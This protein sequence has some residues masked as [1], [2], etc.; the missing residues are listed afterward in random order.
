M[1]LLQVIPSTNP[2]GGGPME[3]VRQISGVLSALGHSTEIASTDA[4]GAPWLSSLP[5]AVHALGPG[6]TSY[7]YT[8]SLVPWLRENAPRF[9]A[10]IVNGLWQ[11]P[12]FAVRLALR[13][14]PTP[15]FVYTHGMLDPWFKRTYPL[16]HLKKSLYWRW[17]EYRVLRDA[18]AV[19]FT[20]E[21]EKLLA[22][23]SFALYR[24]NEVV[25]SLGTAGP[26]GDAAAQEAAFLSRHPELR[27]KRLLLF[28]GRIHAKKGCDLLV[29]AFTKVAA[30]APDLRLVM[31]G[32]DPSGLGVELAR[33]ADEAGAAG[34][35]VWPGMLTGDVKWG[36]FRAAEAF[37]LPSHQENFGIAVAE[38]L[39]CGLPALISDKVNIW[40]EVTGDGAGLVGEDTGE[41]TTRLLRDW[42]ALAPEAQAEMRRSALRCFSERFEIRHSAENLVRQLM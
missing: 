28:L 37:V 15:Y 16:K 17:G 32:P 4:P 39:A 31:A 21:E 36:A 5:M 1:K 8:P 22:R 19:L 26:T 30:A 29:E 18:R 2:E 38:A 12:G 24:A 34:K 42:L 33:R 20:C 27:G 41:G 10:V 23:Q 11:Y 40:R 6:T 14:T 25:V 13:G 3:S 7:A 35:I 9:D